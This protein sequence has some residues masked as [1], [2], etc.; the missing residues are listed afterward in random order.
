MQE[1]GIRTDQVTQVRGFADQRLRKREDPLDAANRRISLIVQY[2]EKQPELP[3]PKT[4][5]PSGSQPGEAASKPKENES[6][7]AEKKPTTR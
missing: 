5:E 4:G 3:V 2:L 7:P 1:N 6:K